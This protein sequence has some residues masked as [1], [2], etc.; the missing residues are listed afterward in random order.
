MANYTKLDRLRENQA[1]ADIRRKNIADLSADLS[2]A[3][4]IYAVLPRGSMQAEADRRELSRHINTLRE[5]LADEQ[6]A[7]SELMGGATDGNDPEAV[8]ERAV[9]MNP[10]NFSDL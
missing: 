6:R 4:E 10:N 9:E 7:L 8:A 3:V 5:L 1:A 2:E